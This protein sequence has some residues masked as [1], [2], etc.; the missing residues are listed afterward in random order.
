MDFVSLVILYMGLFLFLSV[1]KLGR[2]RWH[3]LCGVS[4]RDVHRVYN[5]LIDHRQQGPP[6]RLSHAAS[7][8]QVV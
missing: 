5:D 1:Y 8:S 3:P 6:S 7:E 4:Q 2:L